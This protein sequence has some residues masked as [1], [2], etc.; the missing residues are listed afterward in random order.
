MLWAIGTFAVII[1]VGLGTVAIIMG[2]LG[3]I[4]SQADTDE[5]GSTP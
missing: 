4:E 3:V 2:R 1:A 5:P